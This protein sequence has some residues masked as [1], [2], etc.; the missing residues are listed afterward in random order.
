MKQFNPLQSFK[1]S[2][3][4]NGELFFTHPNLLF[5]KILFVLW[6]EAFF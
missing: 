4:I 2:T 1:V 6:E 5:P 3:S